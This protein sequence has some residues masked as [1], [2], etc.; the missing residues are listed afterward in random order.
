LTERVSARLKAAML[1]G[2]TVTLKLKSAD[3]KTRT[4][5]RALGAPTQLA[6]RIFAAGRDL[7]AKEVAT[8]RFRLIG[9]G[10]SHLQDATG[11]DLA[12]LIGARAAK[13]EH[14]V[15]RLR[16]KFGKDAVVKGLALDDD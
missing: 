16:A 6:A 10:V 1:S 3:F 5:A 11:D 15:D 2:C 9:I 12:D 14:A 4:R 13:A 7:L 8:T